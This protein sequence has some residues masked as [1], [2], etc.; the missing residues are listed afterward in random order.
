M[1]RLVFSI[2]LETILDSFDNQKSKNQSK[3][4]ACI[5]IENLPKPQL[6]LQILSNLENVIIVLKDSIKSKISD[7][8]NG[9]L[10]INIPFKTKLQSYIKIGENISSSL[11]K[12]DR[13]YLECYN[14]DSF[15]D[16]NFN[17][18]HVLTG[19][20]FILASLYCDLNCYE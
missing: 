3:D 16:K 4:C 18:S 15:C 19:D 1:K 10:K 9:F 11:I 17:I 2:N 14:K 12:G 6:L 13:V 7:D 20:N 8:K 5:E